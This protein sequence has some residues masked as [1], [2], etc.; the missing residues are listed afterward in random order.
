MYIGNESVKSFDGLAHTFN[1][2]PMLMLQKPQG[3]VFTR[4][5]FQI[6]NDALTK[7]NQRSFTWPLGLI[8]FILKISSLERWLF[9]QNSL[10]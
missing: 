2:F 5:S 4:D 3:H 8:L 1:L 9:A 10:A 7:N 6:Q